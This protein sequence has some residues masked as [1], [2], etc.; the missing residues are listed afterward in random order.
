[1]KTNDKKKFTSKEEYT[2]KKDKDLFIYNLEFNGYVEKYL[3]I[4]NNDVKPPEKK[5]LTMMEQF[6]IFSKYL[7][8]NGL[9]KI[10]KGST[11]ELL[12]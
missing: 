3:F 11:K 7:N 8:D 6:S 4:F 1:M 9:A 12:Y 5:Q 2:I 10:E